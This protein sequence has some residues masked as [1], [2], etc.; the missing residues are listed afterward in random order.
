MKTVLYSAVLFFGGGLG[1]WLGGLNGFRSYSTH[2]RLSGHQQEATALAVSAAARLEGVEKKILALTQRLDRAARP[3]IGHARTAPRRPSPARQDKLRAAQ[4]ELTNIPPPS[5]RDSP[6]FAEALIEALESPDSPLRA[7]VIDI[8]RGELE[9]VKAERGEV[10]RAWREAK[11]EAR[12]AK[13]SEDADLTGEQTE[14]LAELMAEESESVRDLYRQARENY[15]FRGA[16]SK[17]E[18]VKKATD[19]RLE[20][21]LDAEQLELWKSV[22]E[23]RRRRY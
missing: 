3:S 7:G 21:V 10:R 15:D 18:E 23:E 9:T 20:S 17:H 14:T 1:F 5:L 12:V 8:V 11:N 19:E 6:Q 16:R 2:D 4:I 13:F 22:R